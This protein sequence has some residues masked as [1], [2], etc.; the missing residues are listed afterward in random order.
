[1]FKSLL[2]VFFVFFFYVL[3][4][5]EADKMVVKNGKKYF[6]H[7][8]VKGETIFRICKNYSV[9]SEQLIELNPS[10]SK[11]L[12]LGKPILI[13]YSEKKEFTSNSTIKFNVLVESTLSNV[14][15]LFNLKEDELKVLNPNSLNQLLAG[16]QLNVPG[17]SLLFKTALYKST[18]KVKP[19]T[20]IQYVIEEKDVLY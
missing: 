7:S 2:S 13:P 17:D 4:A 15:S 18:V 12:Q 10:L 16:T 11:G 8:V 19:D 14:A 5:Q 3:S 1:M 9:T 6:S 20:I